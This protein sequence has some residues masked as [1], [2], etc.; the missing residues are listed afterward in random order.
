MKVRSNYAR[1]KPNKSRSVFANFLLSY[2]NNYYTNRTADDGIMYR[3]FVYT[4]VVAFY[5]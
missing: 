3:N 1:N 4:A 5:V 2:D